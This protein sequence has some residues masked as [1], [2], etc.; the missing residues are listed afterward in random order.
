MQVLFVVMS[1]E[2]FIERKNVIVSFP[3]ILCVYDWGYEVIFVVFI[4]EKSIY[5]KKLIY[6]VLRSV[7]D[8]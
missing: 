1:Y 5:N 8:R 4:I 3:L 2:E 6:L 7:L